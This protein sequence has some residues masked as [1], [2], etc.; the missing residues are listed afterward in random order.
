MPCLL[1]SNQLLTINAFVLL[2]PMLILIVYNTNALELIAAGKILRVWK[3]IE[4]NCDYTIVLFLFRNTL[5]INNIFGFVSLRFILDAHTHT[6]THS[7]GD[8]YIY[9]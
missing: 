4:G 1:D 2:R 7:G 5:N 9:M 8:P 6:Y 3:P